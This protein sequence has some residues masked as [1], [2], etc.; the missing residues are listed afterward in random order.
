MKK[1]KGWLCGYCGVTEIMPSYVVPSKGPD[2]GITFHPKCYIKHKKE[3]EEN[4]V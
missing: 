1:V 4:E 2:K 3:V